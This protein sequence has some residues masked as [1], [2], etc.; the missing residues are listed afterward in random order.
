MGTRLH[1]CRPFKSA[2]RV[3]ALAPYSMT[4]GLAIVVSVTTFIS[5]IVGEL[6]PKRIALNNPEAIATAISIPMHFF[7]RVTL[8]TLGGFIMS[9]LGHIPKASENFDWEGLRFEVVDMDR[10]RV[11]KVLVTRT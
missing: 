4:L 7:S 10:I 1:C 9:Q 5:L 2:S 3:P 8:H 11:D 6:V